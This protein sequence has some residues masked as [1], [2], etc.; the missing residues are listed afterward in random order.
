MQQRDIEK[1]AKAIELRGY[2]VAE[3]VS[4]KKPGD[5]APSMAYRFGESLEHPFIVLCET[6]EADYIEQQRLTGDTLG[7]HQIGWTYYR[8]G[9]D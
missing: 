5:Q 7:A 9:T 3:W 1:L 6:D 2:V 8:F 4:G